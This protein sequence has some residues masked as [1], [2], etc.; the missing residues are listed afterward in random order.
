MKEKIILIGGGGHC[1]S[2]I[3]VIEQEGRFQIEGIVDVPEKLHQRILEYEII[4]TD[5]DLPLIAKEYSHFLITI[6][7]IRSAH[8]RTALFNNLQELGAR[9]PVIFSPLSYVSKHATVTEGTIVMHQAVV[10][11]G[12]YIGKNCIINTK[13]LIEHDAVVGD[14]CHISTGA[15]VN[16]AVKICSGT[17][18]GSNAVTK[19]NVVVGEKSFINCGAKIE[20]DLSPRKIIR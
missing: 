16:G 10:N 9:F 20:R 7:H 14:H 1:R 18:F 4:G 8:K 6:G 19:G 2:C 5:E 11:A 13:A 3:D 17:F 12:A 15:I